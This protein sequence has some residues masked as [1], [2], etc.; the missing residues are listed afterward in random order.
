LLK[1]PCTADA[2]S[3]NLSK[4][5]QKFGNS[6]TLAQE[7]QTGFVYQRGLLPTP[8]CMDASGATANMKSTQVKEGS[9]HSMTLSRLLLPTPAT[10][11]YKGA[12]TTEALEEAGRNHTNSL[13][14]AFA[15]TG[16]TSQL[17]PQFVTEMMGFPP[18]YL[19]LPFLSGETNQ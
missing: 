16:Q 10:R 9:M 6:G 1:T 15:Q 13:P 17:N 7:I 8:T 19:V 18:D 5:E 3:E 14:D 4:K 2:Y 11:D 12:R